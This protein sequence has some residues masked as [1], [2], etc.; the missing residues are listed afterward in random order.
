MPLADWIH[1]YPQVQALMQQPDDQLTYTVDETHDRP[2]SRPAERYLCTPRNASTEPGAPESERARFY[3][4]AADHAKLQ[5]G[6][7]WRATVTDLDT[8]VLYTLQGAPCTLECFCDAV[9][10]DRRIPA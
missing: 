9:I 7:A 10:V 2:P 5:R 4:S 6:Y 1:K 8:G 3:I